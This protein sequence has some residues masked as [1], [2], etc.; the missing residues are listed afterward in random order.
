VEVIIGGGREKPPP[1][2]D[3]RCEDEEH[4]YTILLK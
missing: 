1:H 2:L 4:F 3:E